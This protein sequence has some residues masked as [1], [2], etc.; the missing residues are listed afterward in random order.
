MKVRQ[1]LPLTRRPLKTDPL[2]PYRTTAD[3]GAAYRL[4]KVAH[5][6]GWKPLFR[7]L[8]TER[9]RKRNFS[10]ACKKKEKELKGLGFVK[11]SGEWL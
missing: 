10:F 1:M 9:S 2:A 6:S 11:N 4:T 5:R 7:N 3:S 8:T